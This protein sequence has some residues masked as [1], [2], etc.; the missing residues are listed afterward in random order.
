MGAALEVRSDLL[1]TLV[2]A[3]APLY[4][5]LRY[6]AMIVSAHACAAGSERLLL[7]SRVSN[8]MI[9]NGG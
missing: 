8:S 1:T 2:A 7:K 3:L 9:D 6:S 5:D 4:D